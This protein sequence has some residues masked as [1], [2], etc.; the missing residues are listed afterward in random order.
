MDIAIDFNGEI[1]S[2]D[3][4]LSD[5]DLATE[6]GLKSAVIVALFS[7]ARADD[8]DAVPGAPDDRRGWWGDMVADIEGDVTGSKRW[9]YYREKATEA[10]A[11]LIREADRAALQFLID[12][13]VVSG[14]TGITIETEW[15]PHGVLY[16]RIELLRPTGPVEFQF[17]QVWG[18]V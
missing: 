18:S 9:L 17:T 14:V 4:I 5:V 3:L 2:G 12:Q 8:A 11:R 15:R 6:S 1:L 10:T 13:R 7:H 16:E